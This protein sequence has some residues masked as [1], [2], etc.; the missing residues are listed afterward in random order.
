M[1][2]KV[3]T[4]KNGKLTTTKVFDSRDRLV[5]ETSRVPETFSTAKFNADG[6]VQ[7]TLNIAKSNPCRSVEL[8]LGE[9]DKDL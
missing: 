5:R 7:E 9:G 2:K 3:V 6:N 1:I 4:E 8:T